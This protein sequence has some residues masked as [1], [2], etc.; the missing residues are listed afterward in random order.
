[1]NRHSTYIFFWRLVNGLLAVS[2]L[3]AICSMFWE[4]STRRYL[5]GFSDAI[6]P[7][8]APPEE[9]V[10]AI[11]T[12]MKLGPSRKIAS[13]SLDYLTRDPTTTLN[14]Q[15]L[16][17]TCGTATNAFV[18]L[19]NSSN[20]PARRLL[21]MDGN[22]SVKHVV[23]EVEIGGR[24][25]VVDPS[26]R[27]AFRDTDGRLVTREQLRNP[28][29]FKQAIQRMPDYLPEYAF[30][31]TGHVRVARIPYLG[32]ILRRWL[33]RRL[34]GWSDSVF[35]TFLLERDS[36]AALAAAV[37]STMFLLFIRVLLRWYGEK[38]LGFRMFRARERMGHATR[39]LLRGPI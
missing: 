15:E 12:W 33:N 17:K 38:R 2:L 3:V 30:E 1:M 27:S 8:S 31:R 20:L 16:L 39:V 19:S 35:W 10:E 14:Y 21:L 7:L 29:V 18:N 25:F 28:S 26:F 36:F 4:Y 5:K 9:K 22:W 6:V 32:P 34:P 13:D 23:A 37:L 24:W 11:L